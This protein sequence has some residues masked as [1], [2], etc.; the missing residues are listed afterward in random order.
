V[1]PGRVRGSLKISRRLVFVFLPL[2]KRFSRHGIGVN[3]APL[4]LLSSFFLWMLFLTVGFALMVH[5]LRESF[6]PAVQGFGASLY[7]AGSALAT[8]GVGNSEAHGLASGVMVAAG[9]CGLA[10]VTMAV[11]Y[12]LEVQAN[13]GQRDT[14]VLKLSTSAG[15]PPSG[16]GLLEQYAALGCPTELPEVLRRGRDWCAGVVQSHAT[17][18]T[19]IYFRSASVG[20]GWPATLGSLVDITLMAEF[21]LDEPTVRGPAVLLRQQATHLSHEL[22]ALLGLAPVVTSSPEW[23]VEAVCTRL[24]TAGYK[25]RERPDVAG[26]LAARAEEMSRITA[27]SHHLGTPDAPLLPGGGDA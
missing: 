2:W 3:F 5:A 16:L 1:V 22:T 27:L 6:K 19:L 11:T 14:G 8:I 18:P 7:V 23:E 20:A 15:Q 12:L 24:K 25:L 4:V 10:V 13:I 21:L 26:F 9:F 17:H